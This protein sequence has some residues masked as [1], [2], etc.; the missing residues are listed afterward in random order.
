MSIH[1]RIRRFSGLINVY[2]RREEAL[3]RRMRD[4]ESLAQRERAQLTNI[5]S[6]K[7]DYQKGLQDAGRAGTSAQQMK[8]WQ[9]FVRN[10]DSVHTEQIERTRKA[11][12][13]RDEHR[14]AWLAQYRRVKGFETLADN[15]EADRT[16]QQRRGERRQMDEIAGRTK[17]GDE[18]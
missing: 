18:K 12:G 16:E 14:N 6:I 4:A 9:R 11:S 2:K 15:L 10:L 3:A 13:V 7:S 5:E 17:P 8:N 1:D